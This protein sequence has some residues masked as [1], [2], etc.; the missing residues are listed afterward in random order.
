MA[1]IH[2]TRDDD[3]LEGAL[4][5]LNEIWGHS[6]NDALDGGKFDDIIMGGKG[7]DRI[8]GDRG[9]DLIVGNSGNDV[10]F[11]SVD[12]DTLA[13][14][15]GNDTLSGGKGDDIIHGGKDD[16]RINGNSGDDVIGG[17][18]GNDWLSGDLGNDWLNGGAGN[19]FVSGGTGNDTV[20]ASSGTDV[21]R[22][23]EGRDTLDFSGIVG[24]LNIDLGKQSASIN[25]GSNVVIDKI[26]GFE[27]VIGNNAGDSFK[28]DQ[29]AQS[30][31]GG[32][33]ADW[34]RSM[35]G[36][37][38]LS[39]GSGSDRFVF[40]KMDARGTDTISDFELG[41]DKLGMADFL[42]GHDSL[43]DSVRFVGGA[44]N[45]MV[46]GLVG[47][48]WTDIVLLKGIDIADASHA[49]LL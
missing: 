11:G 26:S 47:G 23:G 24:K 31:S 35:G 43:A 37:D 7:D 29:Y 19:D 14:G 40:L 13:G 4:Q 27:V 18:S 45:T 20:V 38:T 1:I 44:D 42:K 5:D 6:G 15:T 16:D 28:G 48:V 30:F 3:A 41:V 21:Y 46:Q 39:G 2:G 25:F 9:N 22:G 49:V 36:A 32:N 33:G 10:I 34:M 17:G 12:N 8:W